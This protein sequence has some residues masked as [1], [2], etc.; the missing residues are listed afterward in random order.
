MSKRNNILF[1]I[2]GCFLLT[3]TACQK[4]IDIPDES[5]EDLFGE[6]QWVESTGGISG[7]IITPNSEGYEMTYTYTKKGIHKYYKGDVEQFRVEY[8]LIEKI[9]PFTG[10]DGYMINYLSDGDTYLPDQYLVLNGDELML[11]DECTDCYT[12][13]FSRK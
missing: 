13:M 3:T 4:D 11:Y 7:E 9:N 6:W 5:L 8:E 10:K 1:L 12:L 2:L